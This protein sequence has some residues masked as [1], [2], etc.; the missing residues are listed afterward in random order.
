[1]GRDPDSYSEGEKR[2]IV[3]HMGK[4]AKNL[5]TD[6]AGAGK[7]ETPTKD[8]PPVEG[9]ERQQVERVKVDGEPA[10]EPSPEERAAGDTE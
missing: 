5:G 10:G 1:M 2:A 3:G 4:A 9:V 8:L 6:D 7:A